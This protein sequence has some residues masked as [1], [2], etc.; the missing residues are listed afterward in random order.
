[1]QRR[2]ATNLLTKD[3]ARRIAA[4]FAKLQEML[5]PAR[6]TPAPHRSDAFI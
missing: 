3:E 6:L 2:S 5:R 1:L 4:N